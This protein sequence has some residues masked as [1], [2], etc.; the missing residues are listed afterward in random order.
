MTDNVPQK[1]GKLRLIGIIIA[2]LRFLAV[3]LAVGLIVGYWDSIKNHYDKWR[4]PAAV[5]AHTEESHIKY[6]CA[7]H[8]NIVRDEP[9][10][11]PLCGMTLIPREV[12]KSEILPADV[13]ARVRLTPR[14]LTLGGI[15]TSPVEKRAMVR[16]IRAVGFLDYAEPKVY[17]MT[18]RVRGRVEEVFIPSVGKPVARGEKLYAIYSPEI[19]SAQRE[20]L[21]ARQRVNKIS[22]DANT[23]V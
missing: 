8:P 14:Q 2:R 16:E 5:G 1:S 7:M 22:T 11:C 13:L 6:T 18:A 12:G 21:L 9:G 20:Y 15:Q 19:Y 3:F 4:R 10:S 17:Q 23:Q